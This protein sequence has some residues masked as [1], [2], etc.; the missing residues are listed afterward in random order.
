VARDARWDASGIEIA[1]DCAIEAAKIS[2]APVLCGDF[3]TVPVEGPFDVIVMLDVIEHFRDPVGAMRRAYE[4]LAPSG[5][6]VIDT[7][8]IDTPWSRLLGNHWYFLDPPQH[9]FYFSRRG[10]VAAL[11]EAGFRGDVRVTRPGRSVSLNNALFKLT[12]AIPSGPLKSGVGR[13]AKQGVR[14]SVYLNFG[15]GMLVAARR[16]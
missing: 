12:A 10:L 11:R 5:Y 13:V 2:G 4:L 14:G 1:P 8:D 9:L 15:D 7:G 6:L 3:A 16:E